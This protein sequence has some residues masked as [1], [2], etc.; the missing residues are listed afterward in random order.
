MLPLVVAKRAT[1]VRHCGVDACG[2][3]RLDLNFVGCTCCI[4]PPPFPAL[5]AGGCT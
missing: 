2:S 5:E 1:L 4:F 3:R